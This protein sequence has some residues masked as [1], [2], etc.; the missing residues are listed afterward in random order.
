MA[1][2]PDAI[3]IAPAAMGVAPAMIII[4]GIKRFF[5]II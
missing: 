5:M 1:A 3:G 2:E 4:M